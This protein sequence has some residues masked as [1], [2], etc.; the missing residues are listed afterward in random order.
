MNHTGEDS[1]YRVG[2]WDAAKAQGL[3]SMQRYSFCK[4][5]RPQYGN[6]CDQMGDDC[7]RPS[8]GLPIKCRPDQHMEETYKVEDQSA[9]NRRTNEGNA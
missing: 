2:T 7:H 8:L 4:A 6:H 9:K 5:L 1:K 3:L